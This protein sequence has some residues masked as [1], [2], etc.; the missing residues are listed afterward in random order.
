MYRTGHYGAALLGYAPIGFLLLLFGLRELALLGGAGAVVL[1]MVPDLDQRVP[2]VTHR[3]PTHTVWFGLFIGGVLGIGAGLMGSSRG[4]IAATSLAVLGFLVGAVSVLSHIA[5]D[6]LTPAGVRPFTPVRNRRYSYN[7][8][9]A[10][11][12]IANYALLGA[13]VLVSG[14][15]LVVGSTLRDYLGRL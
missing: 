5:A 2:G 10:K 14:A 1:A 6:A 7:V 4:V 12:P 13:G 8:A 11:N 3:G 9:T 15:A